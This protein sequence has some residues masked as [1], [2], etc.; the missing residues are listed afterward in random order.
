MDGSLRSARERV[1][2]SCQLVAAIVRNVEC[3]IEWHFIGF[4][5]TPNSAFERDIGS[6]LEVLN[7]AGPGSIN[8]ARNIAFNGNLAKIRTVQGVL[9]SAEGNGFERRANMRDGICS[10]ITH[11]GDRG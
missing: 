2:E 10:Q 1:T 4:V 9:C 11:G 3:R 8:I 7:R 6:S 5:R